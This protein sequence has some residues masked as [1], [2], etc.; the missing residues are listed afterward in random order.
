MQAIAIVLV[1]VKEGPSKVAVQ[2]LTLFATRKK[3]VGRPCERATKQL[4]NGTK[5]ASERRKDAQEASNTNETRGRMKAKS[6]CVLAPEMS[7]RA[8]IHFT[9][10]YHIA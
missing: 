8:T 6:W 9:A 7:S 3:S 5:F 4:E 1:S 10:R 2:L